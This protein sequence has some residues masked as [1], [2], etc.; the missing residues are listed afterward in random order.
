MNKIKIIKNK[1]L[2]LNEINT[3][4][5]GKVYQGWDVD[6]DMPIAVKE[7]LSDKID[8]TIH[9][10]MFLDEA[11]ITSKLRHSN[12]V[13]IYD[14]VKTPD[15]NF[16]IIMEYIDG[17]DLRSILK[18]TKKKNIVIPSDFALLIVM[19]I[20]EGLHYAHQ[21]KDFKTGELLNLVHRDI[22]PANILLNKDGLLRIIDFGIAKSRTRIQN[23]EDGTIRGKIRYMAP[24]QL[25]SSEDV[26]HRVDQ[27]STGV[28]LFELLTGES[29]Y[30]SSKS[31]IEIASQLKEY[32]ID[33]MPY[34]DKHNI[35]NELRL[36]ILKTLQKDPNKRYEDILE[37]KSVLS[38][39][40]ATPDNLQGRLQEWLTGLKLPRRK[41]ISPDDISIT[42]NSQ[43][44][45]IENDD[46]SGQHRFDKRIL[47]DN[48]ENNQSLKVDNKQELEN[49]FDDDG[50]D[51]GKT[52]FEIFM[53]DI[54][55]KYSKNLKFA[56]IAGI[57]L[58]I[59]IF[60]LD[61]FFFQFSKI[62][63]KIYYSI[64]PPPLTLR[65]SPEEAE[66]TINGISYGVTP[67]YIKSLE[68]G[69]Y[70]ANLSLQGFINKS[71]PIHISTS[72][73][74]IIRD[75]LLQKEI[76]LKT[77]PTGADILIDGKKINAISPYRT[78]IEWN[79]VKH[80]S[81]NLAGFYSSSSITY[82]GDKSN[83]IRVV[84]GDWGL[85][86]APDSGKYVLTCVLRKPVKI[87]S[88]PSNSVIWINDPSNAIQKQQREIVTGLG[89]GKQVIGIVKEGWESF[90]PKSIE[91]NQDMFSDT[92]AVHFELFRNIWLEIIDNETKDEIIASIKPVWKHHAT[93]NIP[94]NNSE[95]LRV[96]NENYR[97]VASLEGF[98]DKS[99]TLHGSSVKTRQRVIMDREDPW[100]TFNTYHF[101]NTDKMPI[102]RVLIREENGNSFL[103]GENGRKSL[104]YP[105]GDYTFIASADGY[106][107]DTLKVPISRSRNNETVI[108]LSELPKPQPIRVVDARDGQNINARVVIRSLRNNRIVATIR[109]RTGVAILGPGIYQ[110]SVTLDRYNEV[111][112]D[113]E[114]MPGVDR[115][116]IRIELERSS[117]WPF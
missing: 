79:Q 13:I 57:F 51:D 73:A 7:I 46:I 70:T 34:L 9:L 42:D 100:V 33:I 3:G 41:I 15:N 102:G 37:L 92:I 110:L 65:S 91:I 105:P 17:Y 94:R 29:L 81:V 59:M 113:I 36:I 87:S 27:F 1:Y 35:P 43:V 62:G 11:R 2:I 103:T 99:I 107:S 74:Q 18:I 114:I 60:L 32:K 55:G 93:A 31:I 64:N 66:I 16:Y 44:E 111:V 38:S 28:I 23:T 56:S 72:E 104:R 76:F 30:D 83:P 4:G 26:D 8:N 97:I 22:S 77:I 12:I 25:I 75:V 86:G 109:S 5:F 67:A 54:K 10:E 68:P 96:C 117:I 85:S 78:S 45:K 112:R 21:L 69:N 47:S 101:I 19:N 90:G 14:F 20:C 52:L 115:T 106:L 24:E 61:V 50:P 39:H 6:L 82:N 58:I 40:I 53:E 48:V 49:E 80:F 98:K 88:N 116:R 95:V 84:P 89:I 63:G 71:V 108:V